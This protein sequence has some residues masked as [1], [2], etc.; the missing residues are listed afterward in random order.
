[1]KPFE[2]LM[3]FLSDIPANYHE[4]TFRQLYHYIPTLPEGEFLEFGTGLAKA[5]CMIAIR[6]SKLK[7]TTFDTGDPYDVLDYN[8]FIEN[9]LRAHGINQNV[10]H[11]IGNSLE[12]ELNKEFVGLNIDSGHSYTLTL[13]EL[14]RWVPKVKQGGIIFL[15][16]Y[17]D[18]RVEVKKAVDEFM[19]DYGDDFEVLSDNMCF[20]M[21]KL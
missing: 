16:D 9:I 6:N 3:H 14:E 18:D 21:K 13:A 2:E 19:Q 15:D 12:V 7:I 10:H 5:T 17:R 20:V 4:D 1:M 11:F 8:G